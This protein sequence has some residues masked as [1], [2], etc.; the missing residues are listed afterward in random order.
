MDLFQR[1]SA[2]PWSA[3]YDALIADNSSSASVVRG[4][5]TRRKDGTEVPIEGAPGRAASKTEAGWINRRHLDRHHAA[6]ARRGRRWRESEVRFRRSFELAGS[7]GGA[8]RP[9]T[10]ASF[11]RRQT[12][13]LCRKFSATSEGRAAGAD[14]QADIASGRSRPHRPA[15]AR[16][17]TPAQIE[18]IPPREALPEEGRLGRLDGAHQSPWSALP[19]GR[20]RNTEIAVYDGPSTAASRPS[21]R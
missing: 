9:W 3:T 18:A 8:D 4:P 20:A 1:G 16:A 6:Q 7:G 5:L 15:A 10:G 17:C 12:L 21:R 13:R 19:P 2:A 11:L 14:G